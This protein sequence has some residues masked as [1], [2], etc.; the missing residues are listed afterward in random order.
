MKG[1]DTVKSE[2][3]CTYRNLLKFLF[4]LVV[5]IQFFSINGTITSN[6]RRVRLLV[7]RPLS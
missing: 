4:L 1:E 6:T 3:T 5:Y 2:D 7:S